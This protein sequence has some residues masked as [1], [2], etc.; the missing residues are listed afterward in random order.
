[1]RRDKKGEWHG[2]KTYYSGCEKCQKNVA[3]KCPIYLEHVAFLAK[4]WN[5]INEITG[6]QRGVNRN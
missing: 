6:V 3:V 2:C 5:T 4:R 1:M